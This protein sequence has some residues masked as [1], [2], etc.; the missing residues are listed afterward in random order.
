MTPAIVVAPLLYVDPTYCQILSTLHISLSVLEQ[1]ALNFTLPL[2]GA[3]AAALPP[4][5]A[6]TLPGHFAAIDRSAAAVISSRASAAIGRHASAAIGRDTNGM[7]F[8]SSEG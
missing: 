7:R 5:S 4:P 6:A 1:V 8:W 2:G 3:S